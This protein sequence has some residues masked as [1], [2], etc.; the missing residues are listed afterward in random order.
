MCS[1]YAARVLVCGSSF[2]SPCASSL[3]LFSF[4]LQRHRLAWTGCSRCVQ[5][6]ATP[7]KQ[8]L[9][10]LTLLQLLGAV[11]ARRK[12]KIAKGARDIM[13]EQMIIRQKGTHGQTSQPVFTI[14][15]TATAFAAI[16][17][18]FERH[19]ACTIETPVFELKETLTGK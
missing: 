9:R 10:A 4:Q 13:P 5:T 17:A 7:C 14:I 15:K 18:V 19:G 2:H 8:R 6:F 16:T 12:P 3:L 1:L 11:Q